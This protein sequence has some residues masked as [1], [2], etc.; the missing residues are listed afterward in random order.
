MTSRWTQ[1]LLSDTIHAVTIYDTIQWY[2]SNQGVYEHFGP[3]TKNYWDYAITPDN[4]IINPVVKDI[5]KDNSGNIWIGT[6]KGLFIMTQSSN[7]LVNTSSWKTNISWTSGKGFVKTMADKSINDIQKDLSGNIWV[8]SNSG[9]ES[10]NN[11]PDATEANTRRVVFVAESGNELFIPSNGDTYYGNSEFRKGKDI[12]NWYCVYNGSGTNVDITGLNSYTTYTVVIFDY[13][14]EPGSEVYCV[15]EG[16]NNPVNFTTQLTGIEDLKNDQ[17][18]AFP[19]PFNDFIIVHF[20]TME[21][22]NRAT[23]Y[24]INGKIFRSEQLYGNN[25]KINTIDLAKGVYFLKITD[26]K[27]EEMIKI[28]K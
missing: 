9:V 17:V 11:V 21:N 18:N 23:I 27:N 19:I 4:G 2:G 1:R 10:F 15:A 20:K 16:I 13:N 28:I 12:G 25:Q 5:E 3:A 8:A 6:E 22:F 24:N 26:G 14:G 7:I